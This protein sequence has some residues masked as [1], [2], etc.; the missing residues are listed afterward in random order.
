MFLCDIASRYQAF[1]SAGFK[2]ADGNT[3]DTSFPPNM[4]L[5]RPENRRPEGNPAAR[6][7]GPFPYL[8]VILLRFIQFPRR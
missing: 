2:A 1:R 7:R 5:S 6:V 4:R 8:S 3:S